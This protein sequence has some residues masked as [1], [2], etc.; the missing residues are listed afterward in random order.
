ME[1]LLDGAE[2]CTEYTKRPPSSQT[3][4]QLTTIARVAI[5]RKAISSTLSI[6]SFESTFYLLCTCPTV[7]ILLLPI[8]L[9]NRRIP[10]RLNHIQNS[11]SVPQ[12]ELTRLSVLSISLYVDGF[13]TSYLFPSYKVGVYMSVLRIVS[14]TLLS[15]TSLAECTCT[16]CTAV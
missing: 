8:P 3:T 2:W 11:H 14:V 16:A 1:S 9:C 12:S 13:T 7:N 5:S 4:F 15:S 10:F 6:M